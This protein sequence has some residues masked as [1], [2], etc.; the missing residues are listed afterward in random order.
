MMDDSF[1]IKELE[2]NFK[3]R[4]IDVLWFNTFG[5]I[6]KYLLKQI[7]ST[8]TVGIG[9]SKTL[10]NME[11]TKALDVRGNKVFDKT[12]GKTPDEIRE[13]KRNSLLTDC[14]ISS[15]NAVSIDGKIVNIDHSGNRIAAI[16]YGPDK[17]YIV[18][19]K[20]KITK[21][22]EEALSRARNV[23]SPL[24]ARRAGFNPPCVLIGHCVD[25]VSVERVCYIVSTIEGSYSKNRITL[26]IA[27]E[28]D[29][30]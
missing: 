3:K 24:N 5:D 1:I 6:K 14:Y 23:A 22:H 30:F 25:C 21:T 12:F 4:N 29:G 10:K 9:N 7:P 18:I 11:I 19:G 26:L 16:T 13:L 8:A 28:E 17:V 15:S 27:N 20:N 2:D